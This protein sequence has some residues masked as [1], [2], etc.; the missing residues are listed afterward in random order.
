MSP[1]HH[2]FRALRWSAIDVVARHGIGFI[3]MIVLARLVA[4]EDFGFVA[5]LQLFFGLA[6]V[7][8]DGGMSAALIR[9]QEHNARDEMSAFCFNLMAGALIALALGVCS[10]FIAGLFQR[11]SLEPLIWAMALGSFVN[12]FGLIHV[13]LLTKALDFRRQT[14]VSIVASTFSGALGVV[15]ALNG[16][17]AWSLVWQSVSSSLIST[18]ML[19]MINPWRPAAGLSLD[20]MKRL[21]AFGKFVTL[22]AMLDVVYNR[23]YTLLIGRSFS[24]AELGFFWRAV[25][26]R[27]MISDGFEAIT[28]RVTFP[29]LS[30]YGGER[31]QLAGTTR[32]IL[33][34]MMVLN[35]PSMFGLAVLAEPF[36]LLI[37][38]EHWLPSAQ[39]LQV[40]CLAGAL[41][42]LHTANL[43]ALMALGHSDLCFRIEVL[44]KAIGLATL[45]FASFYGVLAI[46]WSQVLVGVFAFFVNSFYSRSL[47]GYG[48][49]RQLADVAPVFVAAGGMAAVVALAQ[50]A[51]DASLVLQF[52]VSILL[53]GISFGIFLRLVAKELFFQHVRLMVGMFAVRKHE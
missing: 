37:F 20:S 51:V 40:L 53:G 49:L 22:S 38:G 52:S 41:W 47:F 6:A 7:A 42:P 17:G 39:V 5:M 43:N 15:L 1:E 44:K 2:G 48:S 9:Q 27:Q 24:S 45:A 31:S 21:F 12:S 18:A 46:A 3:V 8:I 16:Y 50:G 23:T 29:V 10:P 32:K 25:T 35:V 14:K 11:P 34:A 30:S 33:V 13:A 4:P 36:V 19:W 28:S 26:T